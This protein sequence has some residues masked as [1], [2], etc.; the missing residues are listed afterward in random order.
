MR[1]C[2]AGIQDE[3]VRTMESHKMHRRSFIANAVAFISTGLKQA[4]KGK[5]MFLGLGLSLSP[6]AASAASSGNF[7]ADV[8]AHI[9]AHNVARDLGGWTGFDGS[10]TFTKTTTV[11]TADEA[12]AAMQSWWGDAGPDGFSKVI[13]DWDGLSNF[14]DGRLYGSWKGNLTVDASV[15]G[16]YVRP[17]GAILVVNKSGRTPAFGNGLLIYSTPGI[18]FNGVG[19][20]PVSGTCLNLQLTSTYPIPHAVVLKNCKLGTGH[21]RTGTPVTS[22]PSVVANNQTLLLSVHIEDCDL[23]E[24]MAMYGGAGRFLRF[25]NNFIHRCIGDVVGNFGYDTSRGWTSDIKSYVW[26]EG[27][28]SVNGVDDPAWSALHRDYLQTGTNVDGHAGYHVLCRYNISHAPAEFTGDS[29]GQYN[30]DAQLADNELIIYENIFLISA[31][32]GIALWSVGG[33]YDHYVQN[34][35]VMSAGR[36]KI[37]SWSWVMVWDAMPGL[38]SLLGVYKSITL[39]DN[40]FSGVVDSNN[41]ITTMSGNKRVSPQKG[42]VSGDGTDGGGAIRPE[43]VFSGTFLRDG[44]DFMSYNI[45][46]ENSLDKATAFYAVVDFFKPSGGWGSISAGCTNPENWPNAPVRPA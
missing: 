42:L 21:W 24:V 45:T 32:H 36:R 29:Q 43:D 23:Y 40:I 10:E 31:Y 28:L 27:N 41:N 7:A 4:T 1:K 33:S 22:Y 34:N 15:F 12:L 46:N 35:T 38:P 37:D 11:T 3:Q 26:V 9:A 14:T 8:A 5:K 25:K 13:C 44:S 18:E 39:T 2:F 17:L 6:P 20:A 16:G 19:F 30:D